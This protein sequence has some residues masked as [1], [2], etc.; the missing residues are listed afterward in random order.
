MVR[1]DPGQSC[2]LA[3]E[4]FFVRGLTKQ[5]FNRDCCV[6]HVGC[7]HTLFEAIAFAS[8]IL[9]FCS[10]RQR[11]MQRNHHSTVNYRIHC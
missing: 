4:N 9:S 1:T 7:F 8:M 6:R 2:G 3:P 5:P 11:G 10:V